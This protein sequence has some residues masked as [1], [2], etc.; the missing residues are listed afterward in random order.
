M[1]RTFCI[2]E[3]VEPIQVSVFERCVSL[4]LADSGGERGM[5]AVL[6]HLGRSAQGPLSSAAY[7]RLTALNFVINE[8]RQEVAELGLVS[9]RDGRV[10]IERGLIA[11]AAVCPLL[12]DKAGSVRFEFAFLV[13]VARAMQG[14]EVGE[15]GVC[16]PGGREEVVGHA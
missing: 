3:S 13:K 1:P 12:Q 8:Q 6:E 2:P 14:G 11:A 10:A 5:V 16:V 9:G 15:L 4:Y 7:S